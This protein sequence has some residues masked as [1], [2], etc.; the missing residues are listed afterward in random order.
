MRAMH[1]SRNADGQKFTSMICTCAHHENSPSRLILRLTKTTAVITNE[2][3]DPQLSTW[4]FS[5]GSLEFS[6]SV[7]RKAHSSQRQPSTQAATLKRK[8]KDPNQPRGYISAF[9]FFAKE[10]RG[11]ILRENPGLQ[12]GSAELNNRI[13]KIL[14]KRWRSLSQ[15]KREQYNKESTLDKVRYLQEM[16]AYRPPLGRAKAAPRI[17]PPKGFDWDGSLIK[18][19]SVHGFTSPEDRVRPVSDYTAFIQQENTYMAA[20]TKQTLSNR[21]QYFSQ[22]WRDMGTLERELYRVAVYEINQ[23]RENSENAVTVSRQELSV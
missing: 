19:D 4:S 8:R 21:S 3:Y 6:H 5:Q 17:N 10:L 18:Y 9:N 14:G 7:T 2:H 20:W 23:N 12:M 13:N 15:L 1:E 11:Q 22:R 16:Q